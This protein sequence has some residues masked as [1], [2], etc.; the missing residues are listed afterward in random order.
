MSHDKQVGILILVQDLSEFTQILSGIRFQS[1]RIKIEKKAAVETYR[2]PFLHALDSDIVQLIGD[3]LCFSIHISSNNGPGGT[4][5]RSP[6]DRS[7]RC[8]SRSE[9]HTSELQSRGH[10]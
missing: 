8:I 5:N 9:E 4:A 1:G 6:G 2:D 3:F 7:G 10:L